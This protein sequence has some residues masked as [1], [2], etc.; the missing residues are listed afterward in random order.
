MP[1]SANMHIQLFSDV[2]TP[3]QR[4]TS[5]EH[6]VFKVLVYS[7]PIEFH[8]SKW[9]YLQPQHML[10]Q[11]ISCLLL[12]KKWTHKPSKISIAP[13]KNMCLKVNVIGWNERFR[14]GEMVS[15]SIFKRCSHP[16]SSRNDRRKTPPPTILGVPSVLYVFELAQ[17]SFHITNS[18]ASHFLPERGFQMFAGHFAGL[19]G[20]Q[21]GQV[22]FSP[23]RRKLNRQEF[24]G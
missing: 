21:P 8:F 24:G 20:F 23:V 4:E 7:V 6:P 10:A 3:I 2:R 1:L 19:Q 9:D 22:C 14:D 16:W 15:K 18:S 13:T 11:A 12:F 5:T 17:P